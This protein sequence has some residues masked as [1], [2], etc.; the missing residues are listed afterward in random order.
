MNCKQCGNPLQEE[1]AF[2]SICGTKQE[3]IQDIT[4]ETPVIEQFSAPSVPQTKVKKKI[5][6]MDIIIIAVTVIIS[7]SVVLFA[8][9]TKF[10]K[11]LE[12]RRE[13]TLHFAELISSPDFSNATTDQ[14]ANSIGAFV[15]SCI[16]FSELTKEYAA[17]PKK[18]QQI[19]EEWDYTLDLIKNEYPEAAKLIQTVR[20][21][22][23]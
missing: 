18:C 21:L 1:A 4:P 17:D 9:P 16:E 14:Q 10:E 5:N 23:E 2:C 11:E 15:S 22:P 7:L 3:I 6:L 12:V 19:K 20:D 13:V 8:L